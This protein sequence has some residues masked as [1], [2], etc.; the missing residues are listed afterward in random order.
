MFSIEVRLDNLLH[1]PFWFTVNNVRWGP[2]V[3]WTMSLGLS[4]SGQKVNVEDGVD[5]HGWRK[6]QAISHRG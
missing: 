6:G 1:F 2:F 3:I 4:I 5:L